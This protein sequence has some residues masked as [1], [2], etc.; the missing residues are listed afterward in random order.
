MAV[1][2][3]VAD[4]G[5]HAVTSTRNPGGFGHVL[6]QPVPQVAEEL[7]RGRGSARIDGQLAPADEVNVEPAVS[8]VVQQ[9]N[10]PTHRVGDEKVATGTRF[11]AEAK[12]R[13]IGDFFEAGA[14]RVEGRGGGGD[15]DA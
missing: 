2:V 4:G 15:R 14:F 8:V 7:V 12:P 13:A 3:V 5:A 9:G 10:A 11:V 6:K 1:A